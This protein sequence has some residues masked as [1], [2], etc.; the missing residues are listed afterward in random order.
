ML[1]AVGL[2]L[3]AWSGCC[4]T[5]GWDSRSGVGIVTVVVVVDSELDSD[6][7]VAVD[8]LLQLLL[9]LLDEKREDWMCMSMCR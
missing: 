4:C 3:G 9:L 6:S 7:D 8:C 5:G 2:D 1:V